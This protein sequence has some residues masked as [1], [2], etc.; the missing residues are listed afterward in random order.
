MKK[1]KTSIIMLMI[2]LM[3]CFVL[4]GCGSE[5]TVEGKKAILVV[6]FGTSYNESREITIGACRKCH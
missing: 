5:E 6:S 4:F 2:S 3:G 1:L